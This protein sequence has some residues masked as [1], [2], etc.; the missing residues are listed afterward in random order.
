M[1]ELFMGIDFGTSACK[2]TV[3]DGKGRIRAEAVEEYPTYHPQP[4]YCEQYPDDWIAAMLKCLRRIELTGVSLKKIDAL[5]LD[6][7]THNAV[8]LDNRMNVVRPVIMWTD[9][10]SVKEVESLN[11]EW[12]DEIFRI[13]YQGVATS[14]TLPQLLW[15]KNNEP[16][17]FSRIDKILFVKDYMRYQLTGEWVTDFTDAQGSMLFDMR[18]MQWSSTL[19]EMIGLPESALPTICSPVDKVGGITAEAESITGLRK[20]TPVICGTTDVTA[21]LCGSGVIQPG[22]CIIKLATAG[23]VNVMTTQPNPSL[24]TIT[25]S[26]ITSGVWYTAAATNTAASAMRWFRDNFCFEEMEKSKSTGANIYQVLDELARPVPAGSEGLFFHPYL[27]GERSPYWDANLRGSF[28]GLSMSHGKGHFIR[29]VMEGVAFS[30]RDCFRLIEEMK[31]DVSEFILIG[32]GSKSDTWAQI[33]CEVFGKT[34]IRPSVTDAAFGSAILAAVG[35]G[36]F[37]GL[38]VAVRS[39]VK[40]NREFVPD[41]RKRGIYHRLFRM[42]RKIHDRLQETYEELT[43]QITST[44]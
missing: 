6:A 18:A 23:N 11:K 43:N 39:C 42:Y 13:T 32:G 36:H 8:L 41:E 10:R 33:T 17:N 24:Y 7:S 29:G 1:A 22:Q 12:G 14:W 35:A 38:E 9:Q 15:I 40:S 20:N 34:V 44:V 31:L 27:L 19:S 28:T 21:E 5:A 3:I 16:E 26:H 4:A 37:S 30:L 25:Y 2:A